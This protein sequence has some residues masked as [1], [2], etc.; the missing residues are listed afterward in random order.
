[1]AKE[2]SGLDQD[3]LHARFD[4][5]FDNAV[6][7]VDK[8]R[9]QL[10]EDI[11]N[12]RQS[13]PFHCHFSHTV[14][15]E[16]FLEDDNL[17]TFRQ[18]LEQGGEEE[19]IHD[20]YQRT[21]QQFPD[22][23]PCFAPE[24]IIYTRHTMAGDVPKLEGITVAQEDFKL[25][26]LEMPQPIACNESAWLCLALLPELEFYHNRQW[27]Y[28]LL[29]GKDQLGMQPDLV[30]Y[31]YFPLDEGQAALSKEKG[32]FLLMGSCWPSMDAII[33]K[34]TREWDDRYHSM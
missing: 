2:D 10:I 6:V 20:L 21:A 23:S 8:G 29:D 1:M 5:M 27:R 34:L 26:I 18:A 9:Q 31:E 12:V 15:P 3:A 13:R 17:A 7:T 30:M 22:E 28:F 32:A 11:V 33:E 14:I 16:F 4:E 19:L 24:D 25:L